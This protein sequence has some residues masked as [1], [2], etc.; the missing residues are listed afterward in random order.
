MSVVARRF[1]VFFL[2]NLWESP[3]E[4]DSSL[5]YPYANFSSRAERAG[6]QSLL[7]SS[8]F[9]FLSL[10]D[11]YD[12]VRPIVNHRYR[13]EWMFTAGLNLFSGFGKRMFFQAGCWQQWYL[14]MRLLF[15][16]LTQEK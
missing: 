8:L 1:S 13:K 14:R 11:R 10:L 4:A 16:L 7:T 6:G 15:I 12:Q 5:L 3:S 2:M 9:V